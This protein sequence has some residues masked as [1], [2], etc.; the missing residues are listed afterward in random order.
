MTRTYIYNGTTEMFVPQIRQ[1]V[2]PGQEI[3][4]EEQINHPLFVEKKDKK[5]VIR[6][7]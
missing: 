3:E 1:V 4:T 5:L 2:H 7:K 6:K